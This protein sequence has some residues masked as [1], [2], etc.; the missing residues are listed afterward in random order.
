[1]NYAIFD[2]DGLMFDTER[3]ST[4]IW[5]K[6]LDEAKLKPNMEFLNQIKGSNAKNS[7][8][9][10]KKYYDTK[11]TFDELNEIRNKK[12]IDYLL[13]NDIP[14]KTGLF[15]LLNYLKENNYKLA[16]ASSSP[17]EIVDLCLNKSKAISYFDY[18]VSGNM[19]NNSKPSPDIFL[20]ASNLLGSKP[21]ETYVLEDS[22]NGV[23]AGINANMKVFY[24]PDETNL[25]IDGVIKLKDLN[26][27][28]EY[29]EIHNR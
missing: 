28:K 9:L 1:M 17:K 10:F 18:I 3:L 29:L 6:V 8:I 12:M 7:S 22:Y 11:L 14:I 23:L 4:K 20:L 16:L 2:M 13:L 15:N 25:D 21:S 27:V 26:K 5:F 24:I 19:V